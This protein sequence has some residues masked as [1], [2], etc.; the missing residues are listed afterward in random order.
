MAIGAK[1]ALFDLDNTLVDYTGGLVE[2]LNRIR[3]EGEPPITRDNCYDPP[4]AGWKRERMRLIRL[5]P[6]WWR[7][8]PVNPL[9]IRLF[10]IA[11][12]IGF[13]M[14]ILTRG[15]VSNPNAW[16]EKVEWCQD[17]LAGDYKIT[18]TEDK[19]TV[20]G[21]VL[22]DDYPPYMTAWLEHRA[23][24]IGIMPKNAYNASFA[25]ERVLLCD[26]S[27]VDE[28]RRRMIRSF[29]RLAGAMEFDAQD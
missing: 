21:R 18:I 24:G 22:V 1:I 23:R 29:A 10:E 7:E 28:A 6:G 17:R 8:L 4:A 9:G 2:S 25:H 16:K 11:R 3:S 20:Y 26:E 12:E 5:V 19:S 15:P 13:E 27:N 14:H